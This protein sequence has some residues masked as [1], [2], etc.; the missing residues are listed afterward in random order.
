MTEDSF[1]GIAGLLVAPLFVG[2]LLLV[3]NI[4]LGKP[5][6]ENMSEVKALVG[7]LY[8]IFLLLQLIIAF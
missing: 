2:L 4:F 6:K 3:L 8:V 5:M 7:I 1:I